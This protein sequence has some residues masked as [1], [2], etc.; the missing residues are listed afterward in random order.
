VPV[1][2]YHQHRLGLVVCAVVGR[3]DA[4]VEDIVCYRVDTSGKVLEV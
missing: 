1:K 2:G 4:P 3:E